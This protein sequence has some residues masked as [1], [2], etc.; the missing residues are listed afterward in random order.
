M[1]GDNDICIRCIR[2]ASAIAATADSLDVKKGALMF[3]SRVASSGQLGGPDLL[4]IMVLLG[5]ERVLSR[6]A[7]T[8]KQLQA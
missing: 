4:S 7:E 5:K 8:L 2:T 6:F 3:P 1:A